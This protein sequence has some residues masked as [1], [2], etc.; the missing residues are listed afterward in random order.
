MCANSLASGKLG[1]GGRGG[2]WRWGHVGA[3]VG[4][5]SK[6]RRDRLRAC[7]I[8]GGRSGWAGPSVRHHGDP[9]DVCR[10]QL[11]GGTGKDGW[12]GVR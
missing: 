9:C 11:R 5:R 3:G 4:W 2:M 8:G 1:G 7:M 12:G 10:R 6:L